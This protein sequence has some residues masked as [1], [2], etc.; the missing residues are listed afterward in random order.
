M[1]KVN[2]LL[3]LSIVLYSCSYPEKISN[4]ENRNLVTIGLL[5]DPVRVSQWSYS[6]MNLEIK[7]INDVEVNILF[8]NDVSVEPGLKTIEVY[9]YGTYDHKYISVKLDA[10]NSHNYLLYV[11]WDCSELWVRDRTT[12]YDEKLE[13]L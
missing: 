3:L 1:N 5:R 11:K 2:Y 4:S 12:K 7:K 6:V 10:K 13:T 9:C 8:P